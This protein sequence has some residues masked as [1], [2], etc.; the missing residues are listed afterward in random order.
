MDNTTNTETNK[1]NETAPET[2][3]NPLAR[4]KP[5]ELLKR[6]EK[7]E[8]KLA[9]AQQELKR[10]K[11][12]DRRLDTHFKCQFAGWLIAAAKAYK[13]DTGKDHLTPIISYLKEHKPLPTDLDTWLDE[14]IEAI[15]TTK[16]AEPAQDAANDAQKA[17]ATSETESDNAAKAASTPPEASN[18]TDAPDAQATQNDTPEATPEAA[19]THQDKTPE[20]QAAHDKRVADFKAGQRPW[21]I[22]KAQQAAQNAQAK[23]R[24]TATYSTPEPVNT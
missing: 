3:A 11:A 7:A 6:R 1:P 17:Q 5:S 21:Q 10:L 18:K 12:Q 23:H 8:Q 13:R 16:K 19:S 24:I 22:E 4:L 20:A 2:K 14:R 9:A 15:R